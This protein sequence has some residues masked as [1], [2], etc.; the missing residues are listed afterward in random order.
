MEEL[1]R[2]VAV[3]LIGDPEA[4]R[5]SSEENDNGVKL[6]LRVKEGNMG[7]VIGRQGR[8]ARAI[9]TVMKA[10]APRDGRRIMVDIEAF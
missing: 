6:M 10:A 1:L 7:K 9:R 5:V 2:V 4:V 8:I 3:A